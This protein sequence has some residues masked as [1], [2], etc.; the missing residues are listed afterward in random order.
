MF[1]SQPGSDTLASYLRRRNEDEY[2]LG[3]FL[4][5]IPVH[6]G[7]FPPSPRADHWHC[8]TH[9]QAVQCFITCFSTR[10]VFTDRYALQ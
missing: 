6:L 3:I 9:T 5:I 10:A 7:M 4:R 2:V 1:L 8:I